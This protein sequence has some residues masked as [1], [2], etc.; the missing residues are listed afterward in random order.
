MRSNL[1]LLIVRGRESYGMFFR[2]FFYGV[3]SYLPLLASLSSMLTVVIAGL[4]LYVAIGQ[5]SSSDSSAAKGIYKEYLELAF[6]NPKFSAASYPLGDPAFLKFKIGS[7]EFER[8]EYF[9]SLLLFSADEI[10]SLDLDDEER[11]I[12]T[13]ETQMRYHAL[14]LSSDYFDASSYS[15]VVK[16]L[17][18][19]SL[20]SYGSCQAKFSLALKPIV[21]FG[22]EECPFSW[23]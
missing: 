6:S 11:W 16:E 1:I 14:Y 12:V 8:Y 9:V 2:A 7:E 4:A 23:K 19:A 21:N 20:K 15:D 3:K 17:I 22:E 10:L 18:L 5:L 13:L